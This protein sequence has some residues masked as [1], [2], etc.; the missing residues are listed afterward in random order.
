MSWCGMYHRNQPHPSSQ[1]A[2]SR[3]PAGSPG[4]QEHLWYIPVQ[5]QGE[6]FSIPGYRNQ[7]NSR[8]LL[9]GPCRRPWNWGN[10]QGAYSSSAYIVRCLP[11]LGRTA[12][13]CDTQR[14]IRG[15]T[16]ENKQTGMGEC[17]PGVGKDR[18]WKMKMFVSRFLQWRMERNDQ[19]ALVKQREED[20]PSLKQEQRVHTS[21]GVY[22]LPFPPTHSS[23]SKQILGWAGMCGRPDLFS[24]Q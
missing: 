13:T 14:Q 2:D 21:L 6:G 15:Q 19:E 1:H 4:R 9:G 11:G 20:D 22:L 7:Q 16:L 10:T 24:N 17:S 23:W 18:K 5:R 12:H 3:C 8:A